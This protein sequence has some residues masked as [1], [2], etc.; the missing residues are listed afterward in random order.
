MR[1]TCGY[2]MNM[3]K[4]DSVSEPKMDEDEEQEFMLSSESARTPSTVCTVG[5]LLASYS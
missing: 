4:S 3:N 1:L 2:L 5:R